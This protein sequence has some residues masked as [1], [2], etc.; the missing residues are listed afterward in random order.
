ML[1]STKELVDVAT[2]LLIFSHEIGHFE[3]PHPVLFLASV[4]LLRLSDI[5]CLPSQVIFLLSL[6]QVSKFEEAQKRK[7][8]L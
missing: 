2:I 5:L 6:K 1:A 3:Q 4:C 8:K 7:I